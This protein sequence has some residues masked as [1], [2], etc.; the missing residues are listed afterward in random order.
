M[1]AQSRGAKF[2]TCDKSNRVVPFSHEDDNLLG[3]A[4]DDVASEFHT[5]QGRYLEELEYWG[6]KILDRKPA[7]QLDLEETE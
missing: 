7:N 4:L 1:V 6:V 5:T 3:K 2:T